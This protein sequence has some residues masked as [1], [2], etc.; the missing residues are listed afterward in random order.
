MGMLASALQQALD[1]VA[2]A[3][4]AGFHA[5]PWQ[6]RALRS[7]AS[8][9]QILAAR[10][11]GKS[12]SVAWIA[13]HMAIYRPGSTT[14]IVAPSERQSGETLIKVVRAFGALRWPVP[15]EAQS[16]LQVRL[17]NSSRVIGLPGTAETIVG[18]AADLL[19]LDEAALISDSLLESAFPMIAS[20]QGRIIALSSAYFAR[21]WFYDLWMA[22]DSTPAW[23]KYKITAPESGRFTP[24]M[25]AEAK[26]LLGPIP[27]AGH[28]MCEFTQASG[29]LFHQADID[30]A[31]K[32]YPIWDIERFL[33]AWMSGS[34]GILPQS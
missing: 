4:A 10:Q 9:M 1:P 18:Y 15:S 13:A 16:A 28:F 23:D 2:F 25:L 17:A 32:D 30:S 12:S 27:Y 5:E 34:S 22:K 29:S 19:L 21:G 14:L 3:A 26:R 7:T 11:S 31:I 6:E 24:E 20:S 33:P 8:R